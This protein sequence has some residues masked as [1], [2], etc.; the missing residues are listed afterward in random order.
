MNPIQTKGLSD[1]FTMKGRWSLASLNK[2]K[3][4]IHAPHCCC[5]PVHFFPR[6]RRQER[7]LNWALANYLVR[8]TCF[9]VSVSIHPRPLRVMIYLRSPLKKISVHVTIHTTKMGSEYCHSSAKEILPLCNKFLSLTDEEMCRSESN[10]IFKRF[11][12][13]PEADE[14]NV[15]H[16]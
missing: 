10:C 7:R 3:H 8:M 1:P 4:F 2:F 12:T 6:N 16:N 13:D 11:K 9:D 15:K 5:S 14:T